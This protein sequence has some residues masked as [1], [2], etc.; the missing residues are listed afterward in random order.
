MLVELVAQ[1]HCLNLLCTEAIKYVYTI[2]NMNSFV[3]QGSKPVLTGNG[4]R[5]S[6]DQAEN[7]LKHKDIGGVTA[8]GCQGIC[9]TKAVQWSRSDKRGER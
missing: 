3:R 2:L 1:P 6:L 4:Q 5:Q 9:A 8:V 7:S